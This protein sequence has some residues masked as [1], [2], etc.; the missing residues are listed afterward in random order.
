MYLIIFTLFILYYLLYSF[1]DFSYLN[2][3]PNYFKLGIDMT[4][5]TFSFTHTLC[6]I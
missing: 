3:S 6:Q 4:I 5:N 1:I 2:F